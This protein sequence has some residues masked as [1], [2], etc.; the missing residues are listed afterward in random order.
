[1]DPKNKLSNPMLARPASATGSLSRAAV[2]DHRD[3]RSPP[4]A[5]PDVILDRIR[6]L[7][8]DHFLTAQRLAIEAADRFPDHAGI[9]NAK[10]ILNDGTASVA[11][12]GPQPSRSEEFE[13]LRH[14]PRAVRGKWVALVGNK[15]VGAAE[16]LAELAESL[17][18]KSFARTPLVHR[19]D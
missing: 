5:D 17:K 12:E 10:R 2:R 18:S 8:T 9:Q 19:V 1:M 6:S 14:P 3:S 16:T 4:A 15:L 7:V 13:W 11:A